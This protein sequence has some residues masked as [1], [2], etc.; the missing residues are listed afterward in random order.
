[1]TPDETFSLGCG[2]QY[3]HP[4]EHNAGLV[5]TIQRGHS[6]VEHSRWDLLGRF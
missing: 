6:R 1:M 4:K 2:V 5:E 3:L